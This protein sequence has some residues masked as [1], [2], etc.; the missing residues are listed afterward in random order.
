MHKLLEKNSDLVH[1]LQKLPKKN[2]VWDV[3]KFPEKIGVCDVH[4]IYG[5]KQ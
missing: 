4:K 3:H 2:R 1:K 5:E